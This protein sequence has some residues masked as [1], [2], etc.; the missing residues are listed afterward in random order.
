[1]RKTASAPLL[2]LMLVT[3]VCML[4]SCGGPAGSPPITNS[5]PPPQSNSAKSTPKITWSPPAPIMYPTPL[6]SAQLDATANVP[7]TFVYS[8]SAG[9]VLKAGAQSIKATFTPADTTRYN[10]ATDSTTVVVNRQVSGSNCRNGQ[11]TGAAAYVYVST[12][13]ETG[14][15]F[16]IDGFS[17]GADGSLTPVPGSPF[18]TPGDGALVMT[19]AGSMLFGSDG[20]SI[21]S[22][23]VQSDGCLKLEN[24]LIAGDDLGWGVIGPS[25]IFLDP[26]DVDLYGFVFV[27]P[28]ESYFA[29]YSIS[30]TTG[31]VAPIGETETSFRSNAGMIAFASNDKFA[32]TADGSLRAGV[33]ISEYQRGGNGALNWFGYGPFPTA[34][35]GEIYDAMGAAADGT[36]HF[37]IAVQSHPAGMG[38]YNGP[39]GPWQL[40]VYTIDEVGN[41]STT[42]TWQNMP[43][44]GIP[45]NESPQDYKF[46]PDGR[47]FAIE[48]FTA[49]AV[50]TWNSPQEILTPIATITDPEGSCATNGCTGSGFDSLA[51]DSY[52]HLYTS[53]GQQ[54]L[55]YTVSPSG[56]RPAPGSPH[57]MRH[58][59]S[60]ATTSSGGI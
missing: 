47:Y 4:N 24:S 38:L 30:S 29:S 55:V 53:V 36:D 42:S 20:Y 22:F 50:F 39:N 21:Y 10:T 44:A 54:L 11:S 2:A 35:P 51:W 12:G 34:A 17:V 40:A 31:Q 1:M 33:T 13:G 43:E 5:A 57:A 45:S 23:A 8:P 48:S 14:D 9:T 60:I 19:G 41:L 3:P 28:E 52:D 32:V 16:Q 27:P 59:S 15:P 49:L 26:Q 37:V 18:T 7:G 56:A 6:G 46:S 58:P 25:N